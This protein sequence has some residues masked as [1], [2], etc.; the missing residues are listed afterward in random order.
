MRGIAALMVLIHHF[1]L[2]FNQQLIELLGAD[3]LF[4]LLIV[5]ISQ[6]NVKAVLFFFVLSG[7]SIQ[8]STKNNVDWNISTINNYLFKRF[9]RILPLFWLS[10]LLGG[11]IGY[12]ILKE[13]DSS[14]HL[15]V[16]IGNLLFLHSIPIDAGNWFVPFANNGPLWSLAFEMC[17]YLFYPLYQMFIANR[18]NNR[19]IKF[20]GIPFLISAIAYLLRSIVFAPTF[21]YLMSFNIW[22]LGAYLFEIRDTNTLKSIEK[23]LILISALTV[24]VFSFFIHSNI[25]IE[26]RFGLTLFILGL[27]LIH[28]EKK[29]IHLAILLEKML[30]AVFFKLGI[31]SYAIYILHY[32]LLKVVRHYSDNIYIGCLGAIIIVLLAVKIEKA[33]FLLKYNFLKVNYIPLI[34]RNAK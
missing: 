21:F 9:K 8:L 4:Y 18:V 19:F 29:Q 2:L 34:K 17:F 20:I 32:P 30:N 12:F 25:I 14:Y 3:S 23:A 16:L 28:L 33:S 1:Q 15:S 5:W 27:I 11:I 6:Q 22:Y 7:F 10:V 13:S 31:G 24:F 26:W